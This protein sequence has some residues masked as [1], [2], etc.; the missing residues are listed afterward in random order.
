MNKSDNHANIA[1]KYNNGKSGRFHF[2]FG[3]GQVKDSIINHGFTTKDFGGFVQTIDSAEND[4]YCGIDDPMGLIYTEFTSWNTHMIQKLYKKVN[5]Q[6]QEIDTLKKQV[7]F[8]M[9]KIGGRAD[10]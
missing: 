1:F 9:Q 3:A 7:S 6:Q 4:D 8:L 5:E 2:G 10:E